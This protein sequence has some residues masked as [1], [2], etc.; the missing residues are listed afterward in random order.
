MQRLT[1]L[2]KAAA[3]LALCAA[4]T[5]GHA[6][7]RS[8]FDN[9]DYGLYW[10]G[11]ST[12]TQ[13][14]TDA[15]N[16]YYANY[17]PTM[18]YVHG[19]QNGKTQLLSRE[20]FDRSGDTGITQ[21]LTASWRANGWNVGIFYWNQFSD[22]GDVKDAEGKIWSANSPK[23]M[24]WRK[25]NGS[26]GASF[27]TKSMAQLFLD[28]YKTAMA[29]YQGND[30]RLVG[31]SLGSQM[32]LVSAKLISDAVDRGELPA[33]L[34]PKRVALLDPAFIDGA[35]SYLANRAP[36]DVGKDYVTALTAKGVIFETLATSGVVGAA[37]VPLANKTAFRELKPWY[38]GALD[39]VG[40]HNAAVWH[41]LWEFQYSPA[42]TAGDNS[43]ASGAATSN[44]RT[45]T[46][47]S[48]TKKGQHDNGAWTRTP[49]DD[50]YKWANK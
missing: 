4:A 29:G 16:P 28:N 8:V 34:R 36:V 20:T 14:A 42:L 32:V 27:G 50:T 15:A 45:Q 26:Y 1:S 30:V 2:V 13:K 47:M 38:F 12:V 24:R 6:F 18:I 41:Y 48:S 46:L 22:E 11:N 9:L 40:K 23:L 7:D 37:T 25:A 33:N 3:G 49:A 44:A 17:K 35:R 10:Y 31:H 43:Q 5:M 21:D 19:W 39:V